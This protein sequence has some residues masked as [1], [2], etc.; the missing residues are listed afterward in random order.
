ML[1]LLS[2]N[3]DMTNID[4]CEMDEAGYIDLLRQKNLP[5]SYNSPPNPRCIKEVSKKIPLKNRYWT[6]TPT[7]V[8]LEKEV[9]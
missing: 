5:N 8:D 6:V 1:G 4:V 7:Q 3:T 9:L 2:V